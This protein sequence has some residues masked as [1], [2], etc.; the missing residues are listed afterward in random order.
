LSK[1]AGTESCG[2]PWV[3][4][5]VLGQSVKICSAQIDGDLAVV[6][7]NRGK[8]IAPEVVDESKTFEAILIR[9]NI[10]YVEENGLYCIYGYR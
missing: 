6:L 9:Y 5:R 4:E 2:L 8:L 1:P 7:S 10:P 3:M